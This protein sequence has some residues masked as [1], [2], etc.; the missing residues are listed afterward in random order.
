MLVTSLQL[1][2]ALYGANADVMR[3]RSVIDVD[4]RLWR[5][6]GIGIE[7]EKEEMN[8]NY[9]PNQWLLDMPKAEI[10]HAR[11][12]CPDDEEMRNRNHEFRNDDDDES[13][14]VNGTAGFSAIVTNHGHSTC[15]EKNLSLQARPKLIPSQ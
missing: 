9:W 8:V 6:S 7:K 2:S 1:R 3:E 14:Y 13:A 4:A 12:R 15:F 11:R 5:T 10:G